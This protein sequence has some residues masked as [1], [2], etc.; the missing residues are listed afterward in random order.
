[1]K[2][3]YQK[4]NLSAVW[5]VLST[6]EIVETEY[7]DKAIDDEFFDRVYSGQFV[8]LY[9]D[10]VVDAKQI[11]TIGIVTTAKDDNGEIH[12]HELEWKFDKPMTIREVLSGAKHIKLNDGG[13]TKRWAG[14]T[15][16]WLDCVDEDLKGMTAI[17]AWCTAKCTAEIK[18]ALG[19]ILAS[20]RLAV[21]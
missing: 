20:N 17:E 6:A 15:K 7:K 10:K 12:T 3:K 2:R 4:R 5:E 8:R 13:I 9:R 11:W 18:N 16:Q 21:N 14:V 1:M 19:A